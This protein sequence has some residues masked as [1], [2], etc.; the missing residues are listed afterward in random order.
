VNRRGFTLI[1]LMISL[2][3]ATIVLGAAYKMLQNN[4]RFYRAQG[5]IV[6][7]QQNIRAV[8]QILPGELHELD[9]RG[10]DIVSMSDTSV[11]IRAM[12][13]L[14]LVC[15]TPNVGAGQIVLQNSSLSLPT[16]LAISRHKLFVFREGD[17]TT[18]ADDKWLQASITAGGSQNCADGSAGTRLTLTVTGGNTQLD[19]VRLG[20]PVRIWEQVNYTLWQDAS[21][22]Y[23]L[24]TQT[25]VGGSYSALSAVAGPLKPRNG[26]WFTYYDATGTVTTIRDSVRTMD[27]T[28]RGLSTVPINIQ[29]RPATQ[30]ADSSSVRVA[31]RNN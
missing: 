27:V 14:A 31:L 30:Y 23:W 3:V 21:Q 6:E 20:S 19:S 16:A 18:A 7:V 13:G 9:A 24:A 1:E 25:M 8:T 11:E 4:Q 17:S 28:A 22:I 12:R 10:G 26:L 29:G 5:Q 15:E 2:V